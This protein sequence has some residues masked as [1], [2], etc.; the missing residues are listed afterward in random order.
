MSFLG[1]ILSRLGLYKEFLNIN[2]LVE[3]KREK[4]TNIK[5]IYHSPELNS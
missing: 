5:I 3:N 4:S 1:K 2:W